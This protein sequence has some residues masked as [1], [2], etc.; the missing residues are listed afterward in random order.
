MELF[1]GG[2][3]LCGFGVVETADVG[4]VLQG[5]GDRFQELGPKT[6]RQEPDSAIAQ[7]S[8][9]ANIADYPHD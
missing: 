5:V 1:E 3:V 8:F 2:N 6:K 9:Q 7:P 4:W